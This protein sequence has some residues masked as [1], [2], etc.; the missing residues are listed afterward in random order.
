MKIKMLKYV[1]GKVNGIQMGP[2][3]DGGVYDLDRERAELFIDS[4]MAEEIFTDPV[5][6]IPDTVESDKPEHVRRRR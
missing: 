2:Y 3:L 4:A 5:E 1:N 6:V